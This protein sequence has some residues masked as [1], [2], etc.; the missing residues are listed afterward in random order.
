MRI[1]TARGPNGERYAFE[2]ED[3]AAIYRRNG[4][5]VEG[6]FVSEAESWRYCRE[7]GYRGDDLTL[8][9]CPSCGVTAEPLST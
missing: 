8:D 6:P 9:H 1:W 2:N 4:W 7:C 5:Q 3:M